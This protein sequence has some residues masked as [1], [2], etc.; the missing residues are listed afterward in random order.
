LLTEPL[1]SRLSWQRGTVCDYKVETQEGGGEDKTHEKGEK[2]KDRRGDVQ[3]R[4]GGC[5]LAIVK[6]SVE[7]V[8]NKKWLI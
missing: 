6:S 5:R 8:M 1:T 4:S 7:N 3:R 2:E